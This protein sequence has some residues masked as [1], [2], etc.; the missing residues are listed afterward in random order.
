MH[1]DDLVIMEKPKSGGVELVKGLFQKC[2]D[3]KEIRKPTNFLG[4]EFTWNITGNLLWVHQS[5]YILKLL[6]CYGMEGKKIVRTPMV[7]TKEL[8]LKHSPETHKECQ[9][10]VE[11]PYK[12]AIGSLM[13]LAKGTQP[14]ILFAVSYLARFQSDFGKWHH[15]NTITRIFGYLKGTL[16][17]GL[18][19]SQ[20]DFG[21]FAVDRK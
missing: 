1:V 21:N 18:R 15:W 12:E 8:H 19:Y 6:G 13:W 9:E 20:D 14:D 7:E 17:Y 2:F 11:I 5:A 16:E 10:I 4:W 3:F